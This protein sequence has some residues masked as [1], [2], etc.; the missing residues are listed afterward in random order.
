[1]RIIN[2]EFISEYAINAQ[3]RL[4]KT[5]V[6]GTDWR[7]A[8]RIAPSFLNILVITK[9]SSVL[10]IG[11]NVGASA[12]MFLSIDTSLA[13]HSVD[14]VRSLQSE[15]FLSNKFNGF[16]FVQ[17]DSK[18]IKP[19]Q[20][21]LLKR[22]DLCFIDGNHSREGVTADIESVL[23]FRPK[24]ILFDDVRHPSHSYIENIITEDY[25]SRLDVVKMYEFN[26]IWQGYSM[27]LCKVK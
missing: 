21:G 16:K 11:F 3:I 18:E 12:L 19:E 23:R 27:A 24:Y 15:L 1:M 14:I 22:Y 5:E 9:P 26:D 13:Y 10:E 4:S 17:A 20:N 6:G 25:K 7:F 2:K 8:A